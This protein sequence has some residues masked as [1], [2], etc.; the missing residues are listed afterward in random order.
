[1]LKKAAQ[2]ARTGMAYLHVYTPCPTGWCIP[3]DNITELCQMQVPTNF[4]ALWE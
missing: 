1:M 4:M 3:T 2:V